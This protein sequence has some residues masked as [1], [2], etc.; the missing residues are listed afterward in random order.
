MV[1]TILVAQG[2]AVDTLGD[3][4][5]HGVLQGVGV[6]VV[7]EAG[8]QLGEDAAVP[9]DLGEQQGATAGGD[10]AAIEGGLEGRAEGVWK[11][12]PFGVD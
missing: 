7:R 5:G 1:D 3:Q 2:D 6:A 4:V 9:F 8:S 11:Q 10:V 12:K